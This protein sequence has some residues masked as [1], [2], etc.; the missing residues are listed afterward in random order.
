M[1]VKYKV[2]PTHIRVRWTDDVMGELMF[3]E[4]KQQFVFKGVNLVQ[5]SRELEYAFADKQV[6][7]S[8]REEND[9]EA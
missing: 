4:G 1:K 3:T 8:T 6:W 5:L 9:H 7:G 2:K